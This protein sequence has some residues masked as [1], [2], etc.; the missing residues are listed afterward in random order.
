MNM[1]KSMNYN[2]THLRGS[3]FV[4]FI[5]VI[6]IDHIHL[7]YEFLICIS[8]KIYFSVFLNSIYKDEYHNHLYYDNIQKY[9]MELQVYITAHLRYASDVSSLMTAFSFTYLLYLAFM[10]RYDIWHSECL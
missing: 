3:F 9:F 4:K 7:I 1:K 10:D 8:Y 2:F 5:P 6:G